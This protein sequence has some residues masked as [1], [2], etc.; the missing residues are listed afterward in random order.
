MGVPKRRAYGLEKHLNVNLT[1][2]KLNQNFW[3]NTKNEITIK[4]YILGE[5]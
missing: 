5:N 2:L 3:R 4:N 1:F